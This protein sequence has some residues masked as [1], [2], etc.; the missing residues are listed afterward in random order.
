MPRTS[1][2]SPETQLA[3]GSGSDERL[4]HNSGKSLNPSTTYFA[5]TFTVSLHDSWDSDTTYRLEGP[6]EDD[7]QHVILISVDPKVENA[8]MVDYAGR[9]IEQQMSVLNQ[10]K[11]LARS[12]TK[13]DNG[14]PAS[15]AVFS[16]MSGNDQQLYQEDW[17][18][19]HR[20][21]GYR[22]SSRFTK[23]SLPVVGPTVERL[24]RS[25]EPHLPLRC[26]R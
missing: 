23:Q 1:T 21:V 20:E 8:T 12:R 6:I 3:Q 24:F 11:L 2:S 13:L 10:G 7:L 25:F 17:Y 16:I 19:I 22:L 18:L 5:N 4:P 15:R 9:R 26:R 14:I